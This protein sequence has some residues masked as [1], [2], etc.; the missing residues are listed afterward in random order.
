MGYSTDFIGSF[1]LNKPLD[2]ETLA[3]LTGLASTRR[4]G[5]K[6]LDSK[7]GVEG[8]FYVD[9]A[10]YAGQDKDVSII[11]Y[12]RPPK[13]QP[14]L[15]CQWTPNGDG[16]ELEWDGNEK[17]Y[18][19]VPW[20]EYLIDAVLAPRGYTLTGDV[21]WYGEDREDLGVI[22]VKNNVVKVKYGMIVFT[23]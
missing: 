22:Q 4:M 17:F 12:N 8:E 16:T 10:G 21:Q 5:R 23:E 6:G 19:Y 1:K 3:L 2:A 11:D 7:Y 20:I 14:G 9:A 15:W 13:T 18:E